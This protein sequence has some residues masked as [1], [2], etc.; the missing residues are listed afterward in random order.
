MTVTVWALVIGR[1]CTAVIIDFGAVEL[2]VF[3]CRNLVRGPG[4]RTAVILNGYFS[5]IVVGLGV[6]FSSG[7]IHILVGSP[8]VPSVLFHLY[9]ADIELHGLAR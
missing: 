5:G 7:I 8:R 2:Q 6:G 4:W 3:L 9:C 1:D